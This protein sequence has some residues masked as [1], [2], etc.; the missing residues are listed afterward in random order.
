MS[1][2]EDERLLLNHYN[3][4]SINPIQWPYNAAEEVQPE[5]RPEPKDKYHRR[6]TVLGRRPSLRKNKSDSQVSVGKGNV[7]QKDEP[8]PL[9]TSDSVMQTLRYRGLPVEE[10]LVLRKLC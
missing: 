4:T 2:A 5:T 9:G 10:D 1:Y 6:R 8:D 7:V 3:L